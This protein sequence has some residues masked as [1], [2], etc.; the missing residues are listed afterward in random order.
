M[1]IEIFALSIKPDHLHLLV[2]LPPEISVAK[3]AQLLK[4]RSSIVARQRHHELNAIK[5][6]WAIR[7]FAQSISPMNLKR[8]KQFIE[9]R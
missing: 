3:A 8:A 5:A 7:Y 9:S 6:L 4:W 1:A 2:R